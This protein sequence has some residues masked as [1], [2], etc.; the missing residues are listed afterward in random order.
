MVQAKFQDLLWP[1]LLPTSVPLH[2]LLHL[3]S[4][5]GRFRSLATLDHYK[6]VCFKALSKG[7]GVLNLNPV[8]GWECLGSTN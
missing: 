7:N 3:D 2:L 4:A 8:L 5:V 1:H 6:D